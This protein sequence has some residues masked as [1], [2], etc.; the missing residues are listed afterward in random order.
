[1]CEATR[2]SHEWLEQVPTG[3]S[4]IP[5][6]KLAELLAGIGA[7]LDAQRESFTMG[8]AA[9]V[10]TATCSPANRAGETTGQRA[11]IR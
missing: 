3:H 4:R 11:L 1:M 8:Y 5:P 6:A 7:A 9:V 10:V 2:R